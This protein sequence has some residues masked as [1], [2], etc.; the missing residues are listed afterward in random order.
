M[1][2]LTVLDVKQRNRDCAQ[3]E[4]LEAIDQALANG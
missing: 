1:F 4:N 2:E 3:D